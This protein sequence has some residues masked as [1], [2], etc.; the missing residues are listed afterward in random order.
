MAIEISVSLE[1]FRMGLN[2]KK[3]SEKLCNTSPDY[4]LLFIRVKIL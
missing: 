3:R 2:R 1:L 4:D